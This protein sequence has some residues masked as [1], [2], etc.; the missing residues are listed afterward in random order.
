MQ[1]LYPKNKP[2]LGFKKI[3][4]SFDLEEIRKRK[5]WIK[6]LHLINGISDGISPGAPTY[7]V[8]KY[9]AE[10]IAPEKRY[11]RSLKIKTKTVKS[12]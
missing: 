11:S 3:T 8:V 6:E 5:I 4:A 1:K 10:P 9:F 12:K 2:Y 7:E